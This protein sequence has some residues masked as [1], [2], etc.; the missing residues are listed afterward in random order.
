M[1]FLPWSDRLRAF[2]ASHW[3]FKWV[4]IP[5]A[6]LHLCL[7]RA[8]D[9]LRPEHFIMA[10]LLAGMSFWSDW[11]RRWAKVV[12]PVVLY[13]AVYDSMRW[14]ADYLRSPIIHVHEPY[15]F[16][17]RF[18]GIRSGEKILTPTEWWQLH[19]SPALDLIT[20]IS[21]FVL[22]FVGES[23]ALG[24]YLFGRGEEQRAQR[25]I[26]TFVVTNFIGF[27][28]YYIYPAAPPWYV[29]D[30]GFAVDLSVRASAAGALRLDQLVGLPLMEGFYG[31]SADV[32]GAIP[33]LHVAYPFI[34]AVYAWQLRRFRWLA[35]AYWLLVCFSAVYLNHH[36]VLDILIGVG[37][38]CLTIGGF[39]L[40][41]GPQRVSG[42]VAAQQSVGRPLAEA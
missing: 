23:V 33:S 31:K 38:S 39:R 9:D 17:R 13:G 40:V 1:T 28:L 18:F 2:R 37:I 36:Y 4:A 34:A 16:D 24:L 5:W 25:F 22:F 14:Y 21:Y 11:S 3:F 27:S 7:A 30:H 42:P 26:W 29:S 15:D 20:G 35:I 6:V 32:F 41:L 8:L 19:T 10:G 12:L